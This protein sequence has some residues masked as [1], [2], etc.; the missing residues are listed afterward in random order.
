MSS[1]LLSKT[2]VGWKKDMHL[3]A[4]TC[5]LKTSPIQSVPIPQ[6]L[7][8]TS[9]SL[10]LATSP[11]TKESSPYFHVGLIRL[12]CQDTRL[13]SSI[14]FCTRRIKFSKRTQPW[15]PQT[16][17][18]TLI[19]ISESSQSSLKMWVTSAPCS[20][21][22]PWETRLARTRVALV[23]T[24]TQSSTDNAV[25]FGANMLSSPEWMKQ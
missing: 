20:Q 25:I 21:S 1:I 12:R 18:L 4:S 15:V 23:W 24:W 22:R 2:K 13:P 6:S 16:P 3:S 7:P 9:S 11:V 14:S 10:N 17:T 5:S 8:K 19:T